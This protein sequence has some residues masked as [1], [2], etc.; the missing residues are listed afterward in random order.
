MTLSLHEGRPVMRISETKSSTVL[1]A[2]RSKTTGNPSSQSSASATGAA[3][4]QS[5]P[6]TES[7]AAAPSSGSSPA[8]GAL[9]LANQAATEVQCARRRWI[10]VVHRGILNGA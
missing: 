2:Q 9:E 1:S 3:K 8:A 4:S 7:D 6:G 5:N 10:R